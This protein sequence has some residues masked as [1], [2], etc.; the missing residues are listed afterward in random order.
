MVANGE[1][2]GGKDL[3]CAQEEGIQVSPPASALPALVHTRRE[4]HL[5]SLA[6]NRNSRLRW[7]ASVPNPSPTAPERSLPLLPSPQ[8]G[9]PS[10]ATNRE[11]GDGIVVRLQHLGV[12]EDV[13]SECVEPV[14]GDEQVGDGHPL[15]QGTRGR[16]LGQGS[17]PPAATPAGTHPAPSLTGMQGI[18][19]AF[20]PPGCISAPGPGG[21]RTHPTPTPA[22]P[23]ARGSRRSCR[24]WAVPRGWRRPR[25]PRSAG[26]CR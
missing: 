14:Q 26:R 10:P 15:L 11:V 1:S 4:P 17:G 8:P 6:Q 18:T 3:L 22:A 2:W 12:L 25:C 13:I 19:G 20:T 16:R 9:C 5:S 21:P 7:G 23:A 24:H